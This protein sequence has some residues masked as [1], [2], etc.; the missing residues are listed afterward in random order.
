[1]LEEHYDAASVRLGP[2]FRFSPMH[3]DDDCN[4]GVSITFDESNQPVYA[5]KKP[6]YMD[7]FVQVVDFARR[8]M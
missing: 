6:T 2:C 4:D 7:L 5:K 8:E 3:M 1:M